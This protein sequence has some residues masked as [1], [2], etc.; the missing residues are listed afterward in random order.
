DLPRGENNPHVQ[1]VR[2][3]AKAEGA[4]VVVV[5]A[6]LEAELA[7]LSLE[8]G[9]ELLAAYGL[10]ESGLQRLAQAGYRALGLITFFTAGEKEV[11]AWT[12]RRG[13]KAP[14]AAGEIHS[15]MEK[16]FIRAEVIPWEKLVEAGGWA[17][18]KE[19][20]WVRLEGKDY[21]VQD[22]DV[23]YILFNV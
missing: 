20:G 9:Q 12:V 6:R 7:E 19:R 22:G 21:L 16:G 3:K 2:E 4:E 15:D 1:A 5:S 8:E 11:R 23:L 18:A 17:R 10:R 14:E 13:T